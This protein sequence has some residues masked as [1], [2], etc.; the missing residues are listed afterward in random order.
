MLESP[1]K[2]AG[3]LHCFD[4]D[5]Y[6]CCCQIKGPDAFPLVLEAVFGPERGLYFDGRR[7]P[8]WMTAAEAATIATE[9]GNDALLSLAPGRRVLFFH[10]QGGVWKCERP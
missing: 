2:A 10:H 7:S 9:E 6:S 5:Q 1:G 3:H 4:R 8:C